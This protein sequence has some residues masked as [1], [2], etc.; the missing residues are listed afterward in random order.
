MK[1]AR[2]FYHGYVSTRVASAIKLW[3]INCLGLMLESLR[4]TISFVSE[5]S[6]EQKLRGNPCTTQIEVMFVG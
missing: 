3:K 2:H 6:N 1:E 5:T 4:S